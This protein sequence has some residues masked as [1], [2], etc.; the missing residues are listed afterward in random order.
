MSSR[1]AER[2]AASSPVSVAAVI[3]DTAESS[4]STEIGT[5]SSRTM[6]GCEVTLWVSSGAWSSSASFSPGRTCVTRI[7]TSA[8]GRCPDSWIIRRARSMMRTGLPMSSMKI[9]P[10]RASAA[11]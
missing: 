7:S 11:A 10:P 5:G 6:E 2:T 9:S 8:P 3:A 1:S 4:A